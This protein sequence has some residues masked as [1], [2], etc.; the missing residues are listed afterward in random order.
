MSEGLLSV[1]NASGR[2]VSLLNTNDEPSTT[3]SPTS[4]SSTEE[5]QQDAQQ[6]KRKYHCI[7]PGCN[8][9]FTTR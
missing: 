6:S 9:S 8:K 2:Q 3:T 7:E 4:F 1:K 5:W